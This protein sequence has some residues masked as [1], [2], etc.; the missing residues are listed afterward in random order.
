MMKI[1]KLLLVGTQTAPSALPRQTL[2]STAVDA[3]RRRIISGEFRNG[4]SL[5]Q[6]AIAW[7]YAIS[8]IPLR[9][10]MGQ[11]EVEGLLGAR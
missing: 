2:V 6:V 1:Y 3:L 7:E 9:E 11:L 10:A 5:N 8:R 4:E